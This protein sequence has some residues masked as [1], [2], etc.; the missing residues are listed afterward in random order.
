[1]K[2]FYELWLKPTNRI[3][4]LHFPKGCIKIIVA[5]RNKTY[6]RHLCKTNQKE[7]EES[8]IHGQ[9]LDVRVTL[10]VGGVAE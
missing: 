9:P 7:P 8:D 1:M 5:G 3:R 2:Q 10:G 6:L 4:N